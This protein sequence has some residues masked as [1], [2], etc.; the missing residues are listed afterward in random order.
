MSIYPFIPLPGYREYPVKEMIER[1]AQFYADMKRRRTVREFADRPVPR[2][3]IENCIRAAGTAPSGAN[4]Q[5]WRFVVVSDTDTKK[6]IRAAAEEVERDFYTRRAPDYWLKALAP[7]GTDQN[8]PYLE[9]APYVIV[10]F[11]VRYTEADDGE[12]LHHYY[13]AE[14]VG[15]STGILITALHQAGLAT[16]THTPAPMA[17]L[18]DLLGRPKSETPFMVLVAGYPKKDA[19]V[20]DIGKKALDDVAV[21]R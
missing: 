11:S 19:K 17:F 4:M 9:T 14:S 6:K 5:P 10:I 12:R 8:K 21:F 1:S 13:L 3:I 7:L 18:R 16:L 15:I 2:E 20:P